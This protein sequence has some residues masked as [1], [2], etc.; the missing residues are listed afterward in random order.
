MTGERK[1]IRNLRKWTISS[2]LTC[3]SAKVSLWIIETLHGNDFALFV[4]AQKKKCLWESKIF[5][6]SNVEDELRWDSV[7]WEI[8]RVIELWVEQCIGDKTEPPA[9]IWFVHWKFLIHFTGISETFRCFKW[10]RRLVMRFT[11]E[12]ERSVNRSIKTCFSLSAINS[13]ANCFKRIN[14]RSF[15][16]AIDAAAFN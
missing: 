12:T 7:K 4:S 14:V 16:N 8:C 10:R 15:A 2:S 9:R 6:K 3:E 13:N 11:K 5:R 1:L